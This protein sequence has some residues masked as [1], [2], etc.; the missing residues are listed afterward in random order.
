MSLNAA[1]TGHACGPVNITFSAQCASQ[2]ARWTSKSTR[3]PPDAYSSINMFT[4]PWACY[5]VSPL[6]KHWRTLKSA[7]LCYERLSFPGAALPW[8]YCALARMR[9]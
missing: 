6:T 7:V 1:F 3:S 4:R 2:G 9:W 5:G 8:A